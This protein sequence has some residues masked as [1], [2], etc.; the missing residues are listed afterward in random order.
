MTVKKTMA[1]AAVFSVMA[2]A[3]CG[4]SSGDKLARNAKKL[5][6][7]EKY[8]E[9]YDVFSEAEDT[10]LKR[11][12]EAELYYYM[13]NCCIKLGDCEKCIDYQLKSLDADSEYFGA[14][15]TLGVAYRKSGDPERAMACYESAL[16]FDPEDNS[17]APLYVSLG[18]LYIELGKPVSA[19][20][21]LEKARDIYPAQ[22]DIYAYLSIAYAM[23]LEPEKSDSAFSKARELGYPKLDEIREK[24]DKIKS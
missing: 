6:S 7:E 18:S 5:Y 15:V 16:E 13:G 3:A 8:S 9:A 22:A 23:E 1:L 14:W 20:T 21:Y 4:I 2:F 24:L 17:S 11:F 12:S 19:V 10:G